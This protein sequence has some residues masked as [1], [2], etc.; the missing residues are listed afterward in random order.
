MTTSEQLRVLGIRHHGPGS[1]RA[2]QRAL[3]AFEPEVVLIEGP[4][5]ADAL[6]DLVGDHELVPPVALLAYAPDAPGK[7]SFWPF[8]SFSPEW[9]ALRWAAAR[10]VRARFF[11][12]PAATM[13]ALREQALLPRASADPGPGLFDEEP[14]AGE[15]ASADDPEDAPAEDIASEVRD[16]PLALLARAAGYDDPERWWDDVM[17]L[18][19]EGDP[20]DAINDAMAELRAGEQMRRRSAAD[21]LTEQRREAHMRK[22]LRAE[23]RAG[24]RV[25]VVCG[26][27]HAPALT[28]KLPTAAAD[29]AVLR[30]MPKRKVK[31]TWVPWTH[32]RLAMASG[33]GAGVDSPGWYHH[34]FEAAAAD[35]PGPDGSGEDIDAVEPPVVARWLTDVARVLRHHDLPVSAAHVVEAVRLADAL[36]AL[37]GRPLAGLAE[38]TDATLAVLCDGSRIALDLVTREAVVGERLGTVPDSA[39]GVPLDADLRATARSVRLAFSAEPKEL[40]L[41]LRRPTDLSR[42]RL[43]HRLLLLGV[44]WG[45]PRAVSTEGT[46]KEGWDIEWRPELSV[47]VIEAALWGTTV[48]EAATAKLLDATGSLG[49]VTSGVE[50][51]L[52]SDL[53]DALPG[54]L[55]A[56]DARAASD[57]DVAHLLD[58]FPALVRAQRYGDVR[59]TDTGRLAEVTEA[60][61]ARI[62]AG[63]PPVSGGL[64]PEAA[65]ALVDRIDA[66]QAVLPLLDDPAAEDLWSSS[67][68]ALADR[69]DV[70]GLLG[71]RLVR[72]LTDA[73]RFDAPE[74]AGRLAR[75]LSAGPGRQADAGS[76]AADQAHWVEGFLAGGALL[77]IHDDRVL[78]LVDEWVRGLHDDDFLVV[79]PLLR[80][81][82]GAFEPAE[83]RNLATRT[84]RLTGAT[85]QPGAPPELGDAERAGAAL[86]MVDLILG[87]ATTETSGVTG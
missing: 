29:N 14:Q 76:A 31:M 85:S 74:S 26:A 45:D 63:L 35:L 39:P 33:Y 79:L 67:L 48:L 37:R 71:G 19:A 34:L 82:F 15:E 64:G 77:L 25:A 36:A 65:R 80:R 17:E 42:S 23:L 52:R 66:V 58:A 59:G 70:Q 44:D 27:W 61:L 2:V 9:Q 46:F 47:R 57:T 28:G 56:L 8:A 21:E 49:E 55:R 53:P 60:L 24:H 68:Q 13:L 72:L 11:D 6:V 7:A 10:G 3:R 51:A 54:L 5:E 4:P 84:R 78:G 87:L 22:V 69:A 75:A 16:D 73:G 12:L 43:L 86:A 32:S 50:A 40:T 18:R 38:V 83:R 30:G 20:F 41:D 1:A 81:T 62:C